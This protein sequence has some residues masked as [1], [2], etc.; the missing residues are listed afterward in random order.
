MGKAF[1]HS[2]FPAT[3]HLVL[4]CFWRYHGCCIKALTHPTEN[5]CML[6]EVSGNEPPTSD[7]SW[8]SRCITLIIGFF[9]S[10]HRTSTFPLPGQSV[11]CAHLRPR[12]HLSPFW[13]EMPGT[14]LPLP[15]QR[16]RYTVPPQQE[17]ASRNYY[18][19]ILKEKHIAQK[20]SLTAQ[21]QDGDK[22][23]LLFWIWKCLCWF[24]SHM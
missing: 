5:N 6:G 9:I 11:F 19:Y 13:A 23:E 17:G 20:Y 10:T 2:G 18:K 7:S 14:L 4:Y 15:S 12:C 16:Y 1:I 8:A 3:I 22:K 21:K 24:W